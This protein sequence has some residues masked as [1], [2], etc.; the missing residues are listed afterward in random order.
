[1]T[2]RESGYH[3]DVVI[4]G[5]GAAGLSAALMLARARYSVVVVDSGQPRNATAAHM[6]GFLTRDGMPPGEVLSTG[7]AEVARYGVEFVSGVATGVS[8]SDEG[9]EVE[10]VDSGTLRGRRLLVATG[11]TDDL[12]ELPGLAERWGRDVLHCPFCHGWEVRDQVIGVLSTTAMSV[13]QA[14]LFRQWSPRL[15]FLPHTG[16]ALSDAQTEELTARDIEIVPGEVDALQITEDRLTGVHLRSGEVVEL[17]AL[18]CA[19]RFSSRSGLLAPLGLTPSAHPSGIGDY[20]A[21]DAAGRTAV[22]QVWAAG[23]VADPAKQ[24][25]GAAA[26]GAEVAVAMIDDLISEEVRGAVDARRATSGSR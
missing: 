4:V 25:L 20:I 22:P 23:N 11:L 7:R 10:V 1:M 16:P 26:M 12:P 14:M 13:H 24:L 6:H 9:V 8:A 15:R 21:T 3:C 19:P 2:I 5:G 17:Q 18:V